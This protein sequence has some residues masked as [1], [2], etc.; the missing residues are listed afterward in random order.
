MGAREMTQGLET[1]RGQG[2]E[3]DLQYHVVLCT[4]PSHDPGGYVL[5]GV[6]QPR[7]F[8]AGEGQL[9]SSLGSKPRPG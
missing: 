6:A 3:L 8:E 1:M 9:G 2:P 7:P 5:E 4:L